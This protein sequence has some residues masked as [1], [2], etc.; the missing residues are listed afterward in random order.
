MTYDSPAKLRDRERQAEKPRRAKR[1]QTIRIPS[2]EE[3][4]HKCDAMLFRVKSQVWQRN[5]DAALRCANALFELV[6]QRRAYEL[7]RQFELL[8]EVKA[9]DVAH[10]ELG[11]E[12][13]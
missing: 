4:G 3:C 1:T 8:S 5:P 13:L 11:K 2:A 7:M 10:A 6:I 12:P 9:I